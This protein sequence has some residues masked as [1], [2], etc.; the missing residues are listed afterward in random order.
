MP[1]IDSLEIEIVSKATSSV[2]GLEKFITSLERM[3][4]TIGNITNSSAMFGIANGIDALSNAMKNVANID[5]RKFT[6]I[7]NNINKLGSIGASGLENGSSAIINMTNSLQQISNV[8]P[9][10]A[11]SIKDLATGINRLGG[12]SVTNAIANFPT[13][14]SALQQMMTSLSNTPK[15]SQ[16]LI[17]MT[18]AL[19]NLSRQS[20]N[21]APSVQKVKTSLNS[22]EKQA[23]TSSKSFDK[24]ASSIGL[25][26]AK[27][28]LV[29][30]GIKK[31]WSATE[32]AMDYVETFNYFSVAL[33][34][35]SKQYENTYDQMGSDNAETYVESFTDK[36]K[37]LNQ[38]MTGYVLGN[39]GELFDTDS[40]GLGLDPDKLMNFQAQILGITNS[41][42]L[43]GGAS[44]DTAKALSMLSA[45]MS[46][47]TNTDL[48]EVMTNLKSGLIGQSRALYKYGIDI[49]NTTLKETALAYGIQKSVSAM[50]QSEKMQLRMLA[51]LNQSKVAWGDQARTI[52]TVANQYR[53]LKQQVSNLGR[54]IGNL[55][56]PIIKSILPYLNALIILL[57]RLFTKLGFKLWGDNWL[58]DLN[59][60]I[61]SI[62]TSNI[63]DLD[64]AIDDTTDS[65]KKL[66]GQLLGLDELNV[67]NSQDGSMSQL[68]GLGGALDL[69][70]QIADALADYESVWGK[71]LEDAKNKAEEIANVVSNIF[72]KVFGIPEK[73]KENLQDI[74]DNMERIFSTYADI[75]SDPEIQEKLAGLWEQIGDTLEST[76]DMIVNSATSWVEGVSGGIANA[77]EDYEEFD[78]K[79]LSSVLTSI[80]SIFETQEKLNKLWETLS[81]VFEGD[82]F[83]EIVE[84]LTKLVDV[85]KNISIDQAVGLFSDFFSYFT[86]P[87]TS[88]ADKMKEALEHISNIIS[89]LLSPLELLLDKISDKYTTYEDSWIHKL[90]QDANEISSDVFGKIFDW[91]N[92]ILTKIEELTGKLDTLKTKIEEFDLAT[93]FGDFIVNLPENIAYYTG[94][95]TRNV[96]DWQTELQKFATQDLPQIILKMSD[97]FKDLPS[98]IA[99]KLTSVKSK[100]ETWKTEM[101]QW[102][103][104]KIPL[105]VSKFI[106]FF[107]LAEK[108]KEV[109]KNA[110]TELFNGISE[111]WEEL[112]SKL[113]ELAQKFVNAFKEGF[114]ENSPSKK[115]FKI[116]EYA[117]EGLKL[118]ME[119][120]YKD[121]LNSVEKFTDKLTTSPQISYQV[122]AVSSADSRRISTNGLTNELYPIIFDAVSTAMNNGNTSVNVTLEGDANRLFRVVQ[123][124]S[125]TFT[126]RTGQNAFA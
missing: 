1:T 107:N 83:K 53:V 32:S 55:F 94:K 93:W 16:N 123:Q 118:G 46:S 78:K 65:V 112:K 2:A 38:K 124:E 64:D 74:R 26:Y 10:T 23:K 61:S 57:Q 4:A 92:D 120:L 85:I 5:G 88:N 20:R 66:K 125:R 36:L 21:F 25:F 56:L 28:F 115:M 8:I 95:A 50:S 117:T 54:I 72:K 97:A 18:N 75:L 67:L 34:K 69:S 33:D 14:T 116:G 71:A 51:I 99:S 41:V 126:K 42:G 109:G 96:Y 77:K 13:L 11:T 9:N 15:V 91:I 90:F 113:G 110:I 100:F 76:K 105:I 45:D 106:N 111:K 47:L 122:N 73:A 40:I 52:N 104:E 19:G 24:L 27:F 3:S 29:I 108:M 103:A 37:T 39:K 6:T 49:T 35:I 86:E 59:E 87:F 98:N 60:D 43:L 80:T 44:V 48:D 58:S 121:T 101:F 12:K 102:I 68:T 82:G 84:T 7:A 89:D 114:D 30:R 31:L 17:D 63:E 119:S 22:V 81:E 70:Q 79:T 62:G